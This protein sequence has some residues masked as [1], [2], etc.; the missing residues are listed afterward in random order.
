MAYEKQAWQTGDIVTAAKLNHMEQ[1]IAD[2]TTKQYVDDQRLIIT[3]NLNQDLSILSYTWQEIHDAFIAGKT[4]V[5]TG[6]D[7][8]GSAVLVSG[9]FYQDQALKQKYRIITGKP[10]VSFSAESPDSYPTRDRDPAR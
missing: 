2:A 8:Y 9:V 1:G 10:V 4:C 3:E 7:S 6:I 5:I